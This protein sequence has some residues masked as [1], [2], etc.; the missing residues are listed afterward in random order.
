MLSRA[1][2][3]VLTRRT[4]SLALRIRGKAP[5]PKQQCFTSIAPR[6]PL[7]IIERIIELMQSAHPC[8]DSCLPAIA[9]IIKTSKAFR[10]IA[11]R[12]CFRDVVVDSRSHFLGVW[13][14]LTIEKEVFRVDGSFN[15]VK[16]VFWAR[17]EA[18]ILT[19]RSL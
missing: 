7:E 17:S 8:L 6:F 14:S 4:S 12:I 18:H 11:L 9:A 13:N 3:T 5:V 19:Q 10:E 2:S 1:N 16:L 15:W